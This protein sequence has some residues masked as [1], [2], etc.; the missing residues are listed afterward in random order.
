MDSRLSKPKLTVQKKIIFST[1]VVVSFFALAEAA[2]WALGTV[3]LIELEDPFRGFSGLV[4]VYEPTGDV[5]QTRRQS[6]NTFNEQSFLIQKP[7]NGLRIFG[8]G[9]S[10]AHGFPWGAEA[11]FMRVLGEL[12]EERHKHLQVEAVNAA[13]VSYAMH[14]L[15]IVADGLLNYEPDIFV[16]Y[17]GHNEFIEPVFMDELKSRSRT[18]TKVEYLAAHSRIYTSMRNAMWARPKQASRLEFDTTVLRQHGLFSSAEKREVVE[19]FRARLERLVRRAQAAGVKVVLITVPCNERDWSPERS[20]NVANLSD[21]DR[22]LWSEAFGM[23]ESQLERKEYDEAKSNLDRAARLAPGHAETLYLLGKANDSLGEWSKAS[24][25]Y[26]AAVDADA[27]PIRRLSAINQSIRE[28]A[29]QCDA[30]LVDMDA[31][32]RSENEHGLVGF[33]LIMDYVHPTR[34]CHELIA[35]HVWDAIENSGWLGDSTPA[36][37][38][39]YD[40]VIARRPE[41]ITTTNSVWFFNQGVLLQKQG[42]TEKA[43]ASY[44]EAIRI[45]PDYVPAMCNLGEVLAM[46]G[47]AAEAITVLEQAVTLNAN[48]PGVHNNLGGALQSIG[49]FEDAIQHY[50]SELQHGGNDQ[51][52]VHRNM[53]MA[54]QCLGRFEEAEKHYVEAIRIEPDSAIAHT[55]WGSLL[56]QA[57][58]LDEARLHFARA[59]ELAPGNAE[60]YGNLGVVLMRLQRFEGAIENYQRSLRI[61]PNDAVSH[62]NLGLAFAKS[63]NIRDAAIHFQAAFRLQPDLPGVEDDLRRALELLQQYQQ[64]QP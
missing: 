43:I 7:N 50:E 51:A 42:A 8:M 58:K 13:G 15:N 62:K 38:G 6:L 48:E 37:R 40:R 25:A 30:L 24:A 5:Y 53:G 23:G 41:T 12:I 56:A 28:V 39:L 1:I 4:N 29:R 64:S 34:A 2:F 36:D 9:G 18:L 3:T 27:S 33:D 54:L 47:R 26:Q 61:N 17:S 21:E 44:R 63:G 35:W 11:A 46:S 31:I 20:G 14:R 19:E 16:V 32:C 49:R 59:V 22:R 45:Q 60:N 52:G 57:N 55:Y 10:S